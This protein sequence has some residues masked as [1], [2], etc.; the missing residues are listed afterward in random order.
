M[1]VRQAETAFGLRND[2]TSPVNNYLLEKSTIF[3][4]HKK[5]TTAL[6]S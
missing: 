4:R 6:I 5:T 3:H 1:H 2:P